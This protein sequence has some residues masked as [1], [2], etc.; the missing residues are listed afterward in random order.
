MYSC[1]G[2]G[3]CHM[4][5]MDIVGHCWTLLDMMDIV[6]HSWTLLDIVGR[7]IM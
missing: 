1:L 2:K 3:E 7:E 5:V 4:T 6:G